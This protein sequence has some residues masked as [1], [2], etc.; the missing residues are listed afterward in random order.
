[1]RRKYNLAYLVFALGLTT[2]IVGVG[3]Q[4]KIAFVSDR[5]GHSKEIYVMDDD[6]GNPRRL[7]NSPEKDDVNPS[8]SPNGKHIAFSSERDGN[9]D[10]FD[11]YVMD[12]NGGNQRNLTD[13]LHNDWLPS[14]SPDSEYI[15]FSYSEKD[16]NFN[17]YVMEA[18]G[19]NPQR[20]TN[21]PGDDAYPSWSPDGERIT[22]MS[23]RDQGSLRDGCRWRESAKPHQ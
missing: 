20:L 5:D 21:H 13:N 17:I 9:F 16:G 7:T 1:M 2:L 18:D 19:E 3:S 22:F 15:A 8:W 11:I 12:A 4:A 6:G 23:D 10:I 14:W